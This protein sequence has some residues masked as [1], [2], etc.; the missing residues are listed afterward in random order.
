MKTTIEPQQLAAYTR[1][2][3][4]E[5]EFDLKAVFPSI[6]KALAATP[7]GRDLW[8]HQESLQTFLLR[9]LGPIALALSGKNKLHLGCDQWITKPNQPQ[10]IGPIKELFSLQG[11]AIGLIIAENPIHLPRRSPLGILPMPTQSNHVLFF[12]PDLLLDW[13]HTS[14]DLYMAL[15]TLPNAVYIHNPHDPLTHELKQYGYNFGDTLKN[16]FHPLILS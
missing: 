1:S 16:E 6:Q 12:R 8:R 15:Y 7:T 13:P 14:G 9:K 2:G 10:K 11:F 5:F 3:H 4:I